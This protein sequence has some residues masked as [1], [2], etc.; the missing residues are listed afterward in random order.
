MTVFG[1]K[2]EVAQLAGQWWG[3]YSSLDSGRSGHIRFRIAPG[4][5]VAHGDVLMFPLLPGLEEDHS[6]GKGWGHQASPK[7]LKI[8][9]V[10]LVPARAEVTG[11]L[12]PYH[13][14][15]C[16]CSVVTT[17][18]GSREGDVVDGTFVTTGPAGHRAQRGRWRVERDAPPPEGVNLGEG[19]ADDGS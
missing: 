3:E 7:L 2:A 9:F 1:E 5:E 8:R 15:A 19:H 18:I 17:F 4:D 6:T 12:E 13:D 10:E 11:I 16:G 14:P